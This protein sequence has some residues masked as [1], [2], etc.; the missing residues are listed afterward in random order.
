M[1]NKVVFLLLLKP[2][3]GLCSLYYMMNKSG[4]GTSPTACTLIEQ[5][6]YMIKNFFHRIPL[7]PAYGLYSLYMM[8]KV[9]PE[10]SPT[11]CTAYIYIEKS[12]SRDFPYSLYVACT[13]YIYMMKEV[14]P[15]TSPTAC[16]WPVENIYIMKNVGSETSPTAF[17]S[18]IHEEK[19]WLTDFSYSLYMAYA[20]YICDEK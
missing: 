6:T 1:M 4:K 5:P 8:K 17:T 3:H 7:Q 13:A 15:E 9:G 16:T 12:W 19:S 20:A 2:V 10:T 14:C 18:H 11:T